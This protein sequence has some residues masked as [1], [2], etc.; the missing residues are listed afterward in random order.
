[1]LEYIAALTGRV[2]PQVEVELL[3]ANKE[4]FDPSLPACEIP[5]EAD[6][7]DDIATTLQRD[8]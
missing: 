4:D 3:D 1:M 6:L 8:K 2:N 7:P 5:R